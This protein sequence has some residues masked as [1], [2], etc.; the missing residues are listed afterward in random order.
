MNILYND[1][2]D[3]LYLRFDERKQSV[4]NKRVTDDVV[5]DIGNNNT[6]IGVEIMD[7]SK[8][9]NLENLLPLHY[10]TNNKEIL[11][12]RDKKS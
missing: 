2:T 7:A 1:K 9:I 4:V 11:C 12:V 8:R 3:L 6:I 5:L 10:Y